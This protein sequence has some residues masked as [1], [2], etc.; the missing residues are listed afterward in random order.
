MIKVFYLLVLAAV[1]SGCA[2]MGGVPDG[3]LAP[4]PVVL[5]ADYDILDLRIEVFRPFTDEATIGSV[6]ESEASDHPL[7]VNIGNGLAID[8]NGV[9]FLRVDELL[10][11]DRYEDFT[12]RTTHGRRRTIRRTGEDV[13]IGTWTWNPFLWRT[14]IEY[15]DGVARVNRS[16]GHFYVGPTE[17]GFAWAPRD[18]DQAEVMVRPYEENS[19]Q[20]G[21][22]IVVSNGD[23]V[24]EFSGIRVPLS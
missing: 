19:Y 3:A 17:G 9:L 22:T 20:V 8:A 2:T 12:V 6:S 18:L 23:K 21:N 15:E 1:M 13:R 7:T 5:S 24:P 14:N 4:D 11:M 10:G 16:I